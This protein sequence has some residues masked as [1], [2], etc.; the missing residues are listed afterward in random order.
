MPRKP[1]QPI[2][3]HLVGEISIPGFRLVEALDQLA[4]A[5]APQPEPTPDSAHRPEVRRAA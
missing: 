5:A 1:A 4:R 3:Y 2:A